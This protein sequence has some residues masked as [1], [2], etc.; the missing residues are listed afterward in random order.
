MGPLTSYGKM[1]L[2]NSLHSYSP[3]EIWLW[4]LL[5]PMLENSLLT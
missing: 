2:M 1:T 5:Q 3:E 4:K